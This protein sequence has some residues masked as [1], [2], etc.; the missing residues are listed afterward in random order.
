MLLALVG[1]ATDS[2]RHR[3]LPS[4]WDWDDNRAEFSSEPDAPDPHAP[5]AEVAVET[6]PSSSPPRYRPPPADAEAPLGIVIPTRPDQPVIYGI[7]RARPMGAAPEQRAAVAR[8]EALTE[9]PPPYDGEPSVRVPDP[10]TAAG[11]GRPDPSRPDARGPALAGE[12]IGEVID[13]DP[14]PPPRRRTP[15]EPEPVDPYSTHQWRRPGSSPRP[16]VPSELPQRGAR[17]PAPDSARAGRELAAADPYIPP[18]PVNRRSMPAPAYDGLVAAPTGSFVLG[19]GDVV[20]I[21]VYGQPELTTTA[22][23]SDAGKVR[24]PLAGEVAISGLS[25]NDAAARIAEAFVRQDLLVNPQVN[26]TV[27]EYRSQQVSVIGEVRNP[28]RFPIETR[29]NVLDALALAGGVS[30]TAGSRITVLRRV[31]SQVI[32]YSV[33]LD[34]YLAEHPDQGLFQLRAG[35]TVIAPKADMFYI[36]GEVRSPSAYPLQPGMTVVQALSV[37]GGLTERGTDRRIEIKRQLP[38]GRLATLPATLN[39]PLQ[40]N[41]VVYVRERIF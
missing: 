7:S 2:A 25:P 33:N 6:A 34:G 39:T 31:G 41:D 27:A 24:V 29:M 18:S 35:D 38:D 9:I 21:S 17:V 8:P 22:Y 23:V 4:P 12:V 16:P 40:A 37:G 10:P 3:D 5:P 28:G 20:T 36:Y 11:A 13:T 15:A 32:R 1:C 30:E 14:F 19:P 26:V